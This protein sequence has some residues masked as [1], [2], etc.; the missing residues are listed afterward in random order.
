MSTLSSQTKVD[1]RPSTKVDAE[2][3]EGPEIWGSQLIDCLFL[4]S[5]LYP[6]NLGV[7]MDPMNLSFLPPLRCHLKLVLFSQVA[8][9]P[10][11]VGTRPNSISSNLQ[12]LKKSQV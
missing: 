3:A 9:P 6:Q 7:G 4:C 10:K 12:H 2:A 1:M 5:F 11:G 8:F